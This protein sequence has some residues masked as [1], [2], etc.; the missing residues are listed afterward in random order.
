MFETMVVGWVA[1][2]SISHTPFHPFDIQFV[3][4]PLS[5]TCVLQPFF[6]IALLTFSHWDRDP[7][8]YAF[9]VWEFHE[10]WTQGCIILIIFSHHCILAFHLISLVVLF[11][12]SSLF[13]L[14]IVLHHLLPPRVVIL[15]SSLHGG[16]SHYYHY[17]SH[18][19]QFK[20]SQFEKVILSERVFVTL[21]LK[22]MS[23][24]Y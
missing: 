20:D 12:S 7:L 14:L 21:A 6:L 18:G 4:S 13:Y 19:H 1:I 3:A 10:P 23:I 22:S 5:L 17:L 8:V 11:V 16:Q 24:H 9:I 2:I 15:L